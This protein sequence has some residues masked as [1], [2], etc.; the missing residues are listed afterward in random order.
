MMYNQSNELVLL[1]LCDASIPQKTTKP[2]L[3]NLK[4]I[5]EIFSQNISS[6]E[7]KRAEQ[8]QDAHRLMYFQT[9][10]RIV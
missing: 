3:Y 6:K 10:Y 2:R 1:F 7:T 5:K 8:W 4:Q 9:V